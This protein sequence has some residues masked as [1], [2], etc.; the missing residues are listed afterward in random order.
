M[1]L[2]KIGKMLQWLDLSYLSEDLSDE[3]EEEEEEE[4]EDPCMARLESLMYQDPEEVREI[5]TSQ[6][7]WTTDLLCFFGTGGGSG[8]L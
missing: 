1:I 6:M 2:E 4:E 3:F 8:K 7:S 5:P